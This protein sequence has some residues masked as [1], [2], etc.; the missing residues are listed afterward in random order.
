AVDCAGRAPL[1]GGAHRS[2]LSPRWPPLPSGRGIL[3][4]G[5]DRRAGGPA[6]TSARLFVQAGQ[7]LA[8]RRGVQQVWSRNIVFRIVSS[9]RIQ[10]VRA[11]LG[12]LPAARRRA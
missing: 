4:V 9:F 5:K 1:A 11:T 6:G 2:G 3:E 12:G 8:T 7:L 10:A